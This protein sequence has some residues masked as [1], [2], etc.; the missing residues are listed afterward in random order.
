MPKMNQNNIHNN[1]NIVVKFKYT[2][3][4]METL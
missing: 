3:K 2:E 1:L 4:N